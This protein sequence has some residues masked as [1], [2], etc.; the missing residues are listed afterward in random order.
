MPESLNDLLPTT[1]DLRQERLAGLK[2]L[3][4]DLFTNE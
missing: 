3:F 2:R 4:P 1:P